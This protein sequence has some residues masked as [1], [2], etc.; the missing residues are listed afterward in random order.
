M[1][2]VISPNNS[3][4]NTPLQKAHF[5]LQQ[6]QKKLRRAAPSSLSAPMISRIQYIRGGC[7]C[8]K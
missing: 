1:K 7:G 6:N 5:M 8:G 2:M 3:V 4:Q